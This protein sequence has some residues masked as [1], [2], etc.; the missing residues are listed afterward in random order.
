VQASRNLSTAAEDDIVKSAF[1]KQQT[2]FRASLEELSKYKVPLDPDNE[3]AVKEYAAFLEGMRTKIG[4]QTLPEQISQMQDSLLEEAESVRSFLEGN[5]KLANDLGVTDDLQV[6]KL[7]LEALDEVEK[8]SGKILEFSDKSGMQSLFEA[9]EAINAEVGLTD[10]LEK[11]EKELE[12]FEAKAEIV[13]YRDAAV[14]QMDTIKCRDGLEDVTVDLK[15]LD[16]RP[17]Y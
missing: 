13:A 9:V 8:K 16:P 6:T 5:I 1:I 12:Y 7:M 4:A 15:D 3:K 17:Y 11:L 14:E 10:D 2:Q